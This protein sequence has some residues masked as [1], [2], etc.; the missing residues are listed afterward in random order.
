MSLKRYREIL[1]ETAREFQ[2][3]EEFAIFFVET[4]YKQVRKELADVNKTRV[5]LLGLGHFDLKHWRIKYEFARTANYILHHE[6][7]KTEQ[8]AAIICTL[9]EKMEVL[10]RAKQ[11]SNDLVY[12]RDQKREARWKYIKKFGSIIPKPEE[13]SGGDVEQLVP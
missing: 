9:K 7:Q 10:K 11:L 13:D 1:L 5:Q 6:K 3:D 4:Y 8:S 12:N 2:L